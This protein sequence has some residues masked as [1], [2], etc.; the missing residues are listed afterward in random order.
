MLLPNTLKLTG[1]SSCGG[2]AA[3]LGQA[4]LAEVLRRVPTVNDK[5]LLVGAG[6]ADDAAVYW[7]DAKRALVQTI[8]FFTP[9]VDDPYTFGQI[10]AANALSDVY[11]MGGRPLTAMNVLAVPAEHLPPAAIGEILRGGAAKVKE[12]GCLL[13]GGHTIR[14]PEPIYGLSVTGLV[15]P[16]KIMTNAEARPGDLLVLTKP[17]GTGIATTAI[18]R[19]LISPALSKKVIN[20]MRR[21]NTVGADLAEKGLVRGATDLTGFGMLGHLASMCRASEVSA[22]IDVE[23]VP[24]FAREIFT[25]IDQACIPG[26]SAGN[27]K[28]AEALVDWGKSS[29][30]QRTILTDAQTSGGLLLCVAPKRLRSV[31]DM[32]RLH[33]TLASAIV[34]SITPRARPLI[35][36]R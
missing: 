10:A 25:L 15:G 31:L 12:A 2:C 24:V 21:L 7:L 23:K 33:R 34:G 22:N 8:D 28:T 30:S 18:K 17:L 32:L 36:I 29:E 9:I 35:K 19:G 14:S 4:A 27:R 5:N 20:S 3:K 26:G 1:L 11:A 16:K 6:T 13:V